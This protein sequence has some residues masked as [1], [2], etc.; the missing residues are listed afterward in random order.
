MRSP[1]RAL[2]IDSARPS[3]TTP[4]PDVVMKTWS[5]LPRST[6]L[7]SPVTKRHARLLAG[8]AHRRDDALQVGQGQP[9]FEDERGRQEQ[10]S[11]AADRQVVDRAVHRQPADVA[12]GEE[13]R[14]D[15]EGIGGEG[16]ARLRTALRR[17]EVCS[18]PSPQ[19]PCSPSPCEGS[20]ATASPGPPGPT[21]RRCRRRAGRRGG[22]G[23]PSAA[24]RCRGRAGSGRTATAARDTHRTSACSVASIESAMRRSRPSADELG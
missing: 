18:F 2:R 8:F 6:T 21:A 20:G 24:R 10:R 22:S 17:G 7:V 16:D 14:P 9:L 19:G 5:P 12:A 11:G 1:G 23:R 15:H 3:G 13:D 4:M